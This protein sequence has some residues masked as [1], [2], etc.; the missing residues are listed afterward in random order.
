MTATTS[1][2]AGTA[3]TVPLVE[4]VIT[5]ELDWS[6]V[7]RVRQLLDEIVSLGP[8]HVVLDLAGCPVL[9]AAAIALLLDVHRE[10]RRGDGQLGLRRPTPRVQ[11]VLELARMHQ[12]LPVIQ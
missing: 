8:R 6:S 12:V 11:R 2:P 1:Q 9:D 4:L 7:P 5:G 3:C 10:L